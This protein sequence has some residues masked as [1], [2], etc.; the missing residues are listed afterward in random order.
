LKG[1]VYLSKR[2][3]EILEKNYDEIV[4]IRHQIHM[5]PEIAFEEVKTAA[6]VAETLK[7]LGIE[8]R[9]GIAKT[10][11]LGTLHGKGPGRTVLLRAD[12]DALPVDEMADVPYRSKVKGKMH[13][14]GHDA[15]TSGLL[16]AAMILSELRDSFD[17]CVKFMFQPAEE[18]DGGA[19]PMIEEGIL[20]SPKVD[21]AFGCHLWGLM[22]EGK[23][24]VSGGPIMASP[25]VFDLEIKGKGG[26]GAQPHLTID[27]I[28]VSAAIITA[29][30]NMTGR[31]VDPLVPAVV[32]VCSINGGE[33]HNVI[34]EKVI[35][36]GTIRTLDEE[37]R[38][39]IPMELEKLANGIA[40]SMGATATFI[41]G[42]RFPVL[43]N[44]HEMA[45]LARDSFKKHAG[46]ENVSDNQI[47]S[48]GGEDF[49]YLGQHVPSA[50][51]FIG[52]AEDEASPVLHHNPFFGFDDSNMKLLSK[53][54]A[55]IALDFLSE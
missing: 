9:T 10:G 44:D 31:R 17:G 1:G 18:E 28:A 8:T 41:Y 36:N 38:Q 20:E 54:L 29:F 25:D 15:H 51:A 39:R 3:S 34:P 7:K 23:V 43:V 37:T 42:K 35:M 52:I 46:D 16:G 48:M 2:I 50:Y 21:A 22:K 45:R 11:V 6:L 33:V 14:C 24:A 55:Q 26:H 5:E 47:Q 49:A 40:E 19:L 30:H 13:A 32:S 4:S 12:M 27:P 53:G